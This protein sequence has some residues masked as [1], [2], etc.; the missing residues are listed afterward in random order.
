MLALDGTDKLGKTEIVSV[1]AAPGMPW[2]MFEINVQGR[3]LTESLYVLRSGMMRSYQCLYEGI[4]RVGDWKNGDS[5][6][7]SQRQELPKLHSVECGAAG[8]QRH[9]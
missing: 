3:R 8:Q 2:R 5:G 7:I 9:Q 1:I 4:S 6:I